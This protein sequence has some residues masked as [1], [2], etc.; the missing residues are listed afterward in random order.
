MEA[1][2]DLAGRVHRAAGW[3]ADRI[4]AI[5]GARAATFAEVEERSNRLAQLLIARGGGGPGQVAILLQ[6]SV[7]WL[8]ADLAVLKA[9]KAKVPINVRLT[10]DERAYLLRNSRATTLIT[11]DEGARSLRD[12]VADLDDLDHV[13]VV[14]EPTELGIPLEQE[15]RAASPAPPCLAIDPRSPSVILYT[16]G[17]TGRPKGAVATFESRWR[18]TCAMLADELELRPGDGMIHAGSMA[19][20]SGSKSIAFWLRGARNLMMGKFTGPAFLDLARRHGATHSF[21]VPAMIAT[22][23]DAAKEDPAPAPTLRQISYGGAPIS[24]AL[25]KKAMATFGPIF[26]QVYGSCEAPHPITVMTRSDHES[27]TDSRASSIGRETLEVELRLVA[28]GEE[29]VADGPGELQVRG[30][31]IMTGYWDDPV[32]TDAALVDGWYRTGDVA[33]RDAEGFY[34]IIDRQREMIITGGLNV[35]P[36]EVERVIS[37]LHGVRE[38]AVIGIPHEKWGE[39]VTAVIVAEPEAALT[40]DAII[41]H[42]RKLLAGYKKPQTVEFRE[43]LPKGST[44]KILKRAIREPYW[45]DAERMVS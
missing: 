39:A 41:D 13:L 7:A 4:A 37:T 9:G 2:I 16:S 1:M 21:L 6:N 35:Y 14:D 30:Q 15:L 11:D 36:A 8:E 45:Q 25:L 26:A 17:T 27:L 19:H 20:G 33:A 22:L 42:C 12:A 31:S 5:D 40:E 34:S 38:V 44:G 32:A 24:A 10:V 23:V 43:E 3:H 29:V 18:T 28:S